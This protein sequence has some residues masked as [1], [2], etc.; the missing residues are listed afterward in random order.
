MTLMTMT[1]KRWKL[2]A[3]EVS[4]VFGDSTIRFTPTVMFSDS[5]K[6]PIGDH[7]ST[8]LQRI[9]NWWFWGPPVG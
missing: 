1:S 2:L 5:S 6:L 9:V 3:G 8:I 4:G 7:F